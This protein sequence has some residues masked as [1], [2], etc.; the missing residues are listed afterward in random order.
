M[1]LFSNKCKITHTIGHEYI[2]FKYFYTIEHKGGVPVPIVSLP[3][4]EL[5]NQSQIK[6]YFG[7]GP[8]VMLNL[9]PVP[10]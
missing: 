7:T 6:S 10:K 5:K 2:L 1:V 4:L 8:K 9:G 3:V